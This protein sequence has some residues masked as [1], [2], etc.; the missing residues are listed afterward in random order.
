[1]SKL[2]NKVVSSNLDTFELQHDNIIDFVL[3]AK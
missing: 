1:M 2:G 3:L